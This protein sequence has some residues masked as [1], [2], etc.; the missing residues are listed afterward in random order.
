M[1][2]RVTFDVLLEAA[3]TADIERIT[4]RLKELR[5]RERELERELRG[6]RSEMHDLDEERAVPIRAAVRAAEQLGVQVP[7]E[8]RRVRKS[9]GNRKAR[10]RY[11][12]EAAGCRTKRETVSKAMWRLSKGSGGN[13]GKNGQGALRSVEFWELVT[14]QLGLQEHEIE[15]GETYRIQL[16]N[17]R[18]VKF[19]KV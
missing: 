5:H 16:P 8:Y 14:K 3:G 15:E 12:W 18:V 13:A 11:E 7:P 10:C 17:H 9:H 4:D 2:T 1:T 6:I 19:R